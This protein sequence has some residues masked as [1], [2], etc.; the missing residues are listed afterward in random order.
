MIIWAQ[1]LEFKQIST[2]VHDIWPLPSIKIS[3]HYRV[4]VIGLTVWYKHE[5]LH[6]VYEH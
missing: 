1:N 6:L 3:P 4:T 5:R 2:G